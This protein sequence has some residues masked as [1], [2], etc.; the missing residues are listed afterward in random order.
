MADRYFKFRYTDL[1]GP[2]IDGFGITKNDAADLPNVTRKLWVG[3]AGN[4]TVMMASYENANTILTIPNVPA[5]EMLEIRVKRVYT[6]STA[7]NLV[8]FF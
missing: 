5:G 6:N 8:G 4:L 3:T 7:N 2:G 1:D